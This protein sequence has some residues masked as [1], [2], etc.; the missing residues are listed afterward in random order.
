MSGLGFTSTSSTIEKHIELAKLKG[1][2]VYGVPVIDDMEG[3]HEPKKNSSAQLHLFMQLKKGY[4]NYMIFQSAEQ[5]DVFFGNLE[6]YYGKENVSSIM[7]GV[8]FVAVGDAKD[9]LSARSLQ[10]TDADS[11]EAALDAVQ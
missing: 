2:D 1:V 11:F 7:K 3:R 9:S 4:V 6:E 8:N 5:T 10:F